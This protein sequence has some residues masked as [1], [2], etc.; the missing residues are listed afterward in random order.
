MPDWVWFLLLC[1][2]ITVVPFGLG[3]GWDWKLSRWWYSTNAYKAWRKLR[4]AD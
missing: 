4:D 2:L 3:D 1:I